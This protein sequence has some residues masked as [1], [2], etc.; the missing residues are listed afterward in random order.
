MH[1]PQ[2]KMKKREIQIMSGEEMSEHLEQVITLDQLCL[3]SEYVTSLEKLKARFY[4]NKRSFVS[5]FCDHILGGYVNF[6]PIHADTLAQVRED[7]LDND[8]DFDGSD[9]L[10]WSKTTPTDLYLITIAVSPE[11]RGSQVTRLLVQAFISELKALREEGYLFD[12]MYAMVVTQDGQRFLG[13]L[14]FVPDPQSE[15]LWVADSNELC[16]LRPRDQ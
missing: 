11:H 7:G 5:I 1:A 13:R 10:P 14:G 4:A 2:D 9:V 16:L 3:S 8:I 6:F 12:R 15:S